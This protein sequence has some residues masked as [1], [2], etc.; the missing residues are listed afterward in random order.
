MVNSKSWPIAIFH[1]HPV[2]PTAIF[3]L[4]SLKQGSHDVYL[5]NKSI[6]VHCTERFLA[7]WP[8]QFSCGTLAASSL[9][10][11]CY[12]SCHFVSLPY[13]RKPDTTSIS[14]NARGVLSTLAVRCFIT[15]DA[16]CLPAPVPNTI[17]VAGV[18]VTDA[19]H[20]TVLLHDQ[21]SLV[22]PSRSQMFKFVYMST[23]TDAP[24]STFSESLLTSHALAPPYL[25][26][27]RA[28]FRPH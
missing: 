10:S 22:I 25:R 4:C 21:A 23:N 24:H 7:F 16:N 9:Y 19:P 18:S 28:H 17:T 20:S 27:P 26:Q 2:A 3:S 6:T 1:S 5:T 14:C 8:V 15:R 11:E 12:V 13:K